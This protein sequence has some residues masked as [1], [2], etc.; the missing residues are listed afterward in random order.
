MND[1]K[2]PSLFLQLSW[3]IA[4]FCLLLFGVGCIFADPLAW[5]KGVLFGGLFTILRLK[6][7]EIAVKKAV[8]KPSGRAS[9]YMSAQYFIRYLMS[10]AVLIVGAGT[11]HRCPC[12][13]AGHAFPEGGDLCANAVG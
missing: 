4:A 3:K 13:G 1:T 8:S 11:V 7:M 12:H 6:M 2:T 5:G 9:G 10:A